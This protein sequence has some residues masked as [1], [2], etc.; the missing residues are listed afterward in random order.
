MG[1]LVH[2]HTIIT[3][4]CNVDRNVKPL[5]DPDW[6]SKC[7]CACGGGGGGGIL[8]SYNEIYR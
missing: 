5:R 7:V 1:H 3:K 6:F 8:I 4:L 2:K